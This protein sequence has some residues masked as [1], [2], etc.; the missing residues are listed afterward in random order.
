MDSIFFYLLCTVC[1]SF[2]YCAHVCLSNCRRPSGG[3]YLAQQILNLV[4][5]LNLKIKSKKRTFIHNYNISKIIRLRIARSNL[6]N[7]LIIRYCVY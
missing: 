4:Q 7:E 2:D 3:I 5:M 1:L 6:K